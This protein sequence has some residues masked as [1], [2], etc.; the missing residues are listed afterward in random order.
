MK[1]FMQNK[2]SVVELIINNTIYTI[3]LIIFPPRV[4]G[5]GQTPIPCLPPSLTL[6]TL[7]LAPA[8]PLP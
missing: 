8:N 5:T 2:G 3:L 1:G 4:S 7:P 6:P